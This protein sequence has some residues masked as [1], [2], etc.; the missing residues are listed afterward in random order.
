MGKL[1]ASESSQGSKAL[2]LLRM[3]LLTGALAG[4]P[5]AH[6]A[7]LVILPCRVLWRLAW[8]QQSPQLLPSLLCAVFL[9]NPKNEK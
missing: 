2:L 4:F 5:K 9:A 6:L 7:F 1:R 8:A 3:L